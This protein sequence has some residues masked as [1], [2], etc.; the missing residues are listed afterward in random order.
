M[1]VTFAAVRKIVLSLVSASALH[2]DSANCSSERACRSLITTVS[3]DER[4]NL[5]FLF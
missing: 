3:F 4:Q 2:L 5:A 1:P